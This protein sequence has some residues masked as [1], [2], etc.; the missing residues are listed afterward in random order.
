M[1]L[2]RATGANYQFLSILFNF[3]KKTDFANCP[4]NLVNA[5]IIKYKDLFEVIIKD[6][7]SENEYLNNLIKPDD[8][9]SFLLKDSDFFMNKIQIIKKPF[10]F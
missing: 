2:K 7:K 10:F 5:K 8:L 6:F 3:T 1:I 4:K 9:F